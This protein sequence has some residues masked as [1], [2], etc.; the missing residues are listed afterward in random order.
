MTKHVADNKISRSDLRENNSRLQTYHHKGASQNNPNPA[1]EIMF[2]NI[3]VF[4]T[5]QPEHTML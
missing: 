1:T 3:F 2:K 5:L 4:G